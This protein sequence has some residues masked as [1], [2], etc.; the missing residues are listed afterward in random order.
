MDE[1][2]TPST[3]AP[4]ALRWGVRFEQTTDS[5]RITNN[6]LTLTLDGPAPARL[7]AF[8]DRLDGEHSI[9]QLCSISGLSPKDAADLLASLDGH[10]MLR[11]AVPLAAARMT[12]DAFA[13]LC[14][15]CIAPW[16]QQLFGHSLWRSLSE[17]A[18]PR[19]VFDG[20][21]L[22]NFHLIEGVTLRLGA[23]VAHCAEPAVRQHFIKHFAEEY[24]HC[25][26]FHRSLTVLGVRDEDLSHSQPLTATR[27]V[28]DWMRDAARQDPLAYAACSAF[29]ESTGADRGS[30]DDFYDRLSAA[31]DARAVKY[32]ASHAKL[33][34]E[35]GHVGFLEKICAELGEFDHA[36]ADR[37]LRYLA[38]FVETLEL[39][40]TCIERHYSGGAPLFPGSVRIYGAPRPT[41]SES[42]TSCT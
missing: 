22:E 21:V 20:W 8:L 11:S 29:L 14:R 17:G 40:S 15:E 4:G 3:P 27:A 32:M 37:A 18:A 10:G 16:K 23:A 19:S 13:A 24:N 26:F 2:N 33:D 12:G 25:E 36:R 9:E 42:R 38:G 31:Y 1:T 35:Y 5:L 39:W 7:R 30:A 41:S 34:E 6:E 28:I